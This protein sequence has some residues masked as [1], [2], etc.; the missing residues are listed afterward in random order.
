MHDRRENASLRRLPPSQ[1]PKSGVLTFAVGEEGKGVEG[2]MR[3]GGG[4]GESGLACRQ[5]GHWRAPLKT[6]ARNLSLLLL[7][8][9]SAPLL[10]R[11]Q[12]LRS[13]E[14]MTYAIIRNP[15]CPSDWRRAGGWGEGGKKRSNE[16]AKSASLQL[17]QAGELNAH[18]GT[19]RVVRLRA[20]V[21]VGGLK[22]FD[23]QVGFEMEGRD[24]E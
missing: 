13:A 14:W 15:R 7:L 20:V 21:I 23:E 24:G 17:P 18:L 10:R 12:R 8:D 6:R 9:F 11:L 1:E 2:K 5:N 3:G 4:R 22:W 19:L 16:R